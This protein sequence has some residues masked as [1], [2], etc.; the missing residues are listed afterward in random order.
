VQK[1][2]AALSVTKLDGTNWCNA[3]SASL[4]AKE[5]DYFVYLGYNATD[6]VVIC[7]SRIP[8][9]TRYDSFSTTTTNEKYCAISTITNAA[10]GDYYTVIGRFAATLSAGAGYTWTVSTFTNANL[11]QRPIFETRIL[12]FQPVYTNLTEGGGAKSY[13]YQIAGNTIKL[14]V[15]LT[16]DGTSAVSGSPSFTIPFAKGSYYGGLQSAPVS[17]FVKLYDQSAGVVYQ[18]LGSVVTGLS[19]FAIAT[20]STYASQTAISSTIPFTWTTS[21]AVNISTEYYI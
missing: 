20:G 12:D 7:F 6:G 21:D 10:A 4:A 2:T 9:G 13:K 8:Y 5:I 19:F 3:G 11:I 15:G 1:I 17:I 14:D 18:G 16:F